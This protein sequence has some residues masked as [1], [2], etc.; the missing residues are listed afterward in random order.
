MATI[1]RQR[2]ERQGADL[3]EASRVFVGVRRCGFGRDRTAI[4]EVPGV[5]RG[6]DTRV[7]NRHGE[8]STSVDEVCREVRLGAGLCAD[9]ECIGCTAPVRA[10]DRDV[11]IV[12]GR[13]VERAAVGVGHA[14][15]AAGVQRQTVSKHPLIR[16][17][18]VAVRREGDIE[19]RATRQDVGIQRHARRCEHLHVRRHRRLANRRA[20]RQCHG[21]S[22][23]GAIDVLG[24]L[25]KTLPAI[26]EGPVPPRDR[27]A[28]WR[29]RQIRE[30]SRFPFTHRRGGKIHTRLR[31]NGHKIRDAPRATMHIRLGQRN[32]MAPNA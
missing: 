1:V 5:A 17:R 27:S 13:R 11:D 16:P 32:H 2:H 23:C 22:P 7:E 28:V 18:H 29:S 4:A 25:G 6:A 26:A 15:A 21:V 24:V 30:N 31:V 10:G 8:W 14:A 3:H 20:H 12:R 9:N 19:R